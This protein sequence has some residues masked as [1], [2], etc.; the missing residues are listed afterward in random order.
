MPRR[1]WKG[2]VL[3]D[4]EGVAAW[5]PPW[6]DGQDGLFSPTGPGTSTRRR[7]AIFGRPFPWFFL[8]GAQ[9]KEHKKNLLEFF[10]EMDY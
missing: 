8:L 9:K 4:P 3:S 7:K 1:A 5:M 10:K 2:Q 6:A